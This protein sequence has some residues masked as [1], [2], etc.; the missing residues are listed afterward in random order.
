MRKTGIG[1]M[2]INR[3]WSLFC[4]EEGTNNTKA[5]SRK[6]SLKEQAEK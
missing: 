6:A 1:E 4:A 5:Q 2:V 3:M